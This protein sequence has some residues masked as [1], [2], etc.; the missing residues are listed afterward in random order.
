MLLLDTTT[1]Q[2]YTYLMYQFLLLLEQ[3]QEQV[4]KSKDAHN[5]VRSED[6]V[7]AHVA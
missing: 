3:Q 7:H 1:C 5:L 4:I 6:V 2:V